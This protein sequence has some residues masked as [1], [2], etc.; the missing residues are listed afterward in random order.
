MR[1]QTLAEVESLLLGAQVP[2]SRIYSIKDI[3]E[4][5]QY[6]AR[7]NMV[8]IED[9]FLGRI[10]IKG[11]TPRFSLTPGRIEHTGQPLGA[12]N[13][14]VFC[15]ILGMSEEEFSQLEQEGVI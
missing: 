2:V 14:Q 13:R 5:P 6:R 7:G 11:F 15:G 9:E 8:D 12:W 4:D 1:S 3:Y 10:T